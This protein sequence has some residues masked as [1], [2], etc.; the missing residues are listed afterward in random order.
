MRKIRV[1]RKEWLTS[2]NLGIFAVVI[3]KMALNVMHA[4]VC[5]D[6]VFI[7]GFSSR[8]PVDEIRLVSWY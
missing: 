3:N 7:R 1:R 5:C 6:T 8:L 4:P 2:V